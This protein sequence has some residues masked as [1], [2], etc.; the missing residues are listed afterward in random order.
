[1]ASDETERPWVLRELQRR[2]AADLCRFAEALRADAVAARAQA[3]YER[4]RAATMREAAATV[5]R[6]IAEQRERRKPPSDLQS[7]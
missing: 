2:D 7:D 3:A 1:M 6:L 5:W 4:E